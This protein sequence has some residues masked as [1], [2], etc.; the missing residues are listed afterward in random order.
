MKV[1][2][3]VVSPGG[4][5]FDINCGVRLLRTDLNSVRLEPRLSSLVDN[6]YRDIP[7]GLGTQGRIRL[8]A[9][10]VDAVLEKGARWAVEQGYGYLEDLSMTEESGEMLGADAGLVS[11]R[12]KERGAGQLGTLGSGNHFVEIA[13]VDEIYDTETART[14]GLNNLEQVVLWIHT[15]SRG[16]GHQVADD[17]IKTMLKAMARYSIQVPDRQLACSPVMSCESQQYL[18]AMRSAANYAWTNRQL[19]THWARQAFVKTLGL[20][21]KDIG[22]QMVYDIAHNIAKIETHQLNGRQV[23][24]CVHRKGATRAFPP[25]HPD[26]PARYRQVGQPVLIPGDM[27]RYSFVMA[28]TDKAMQDTFGSTCH[29]AGRLKSRTAAKKSI[30]GREFVHSLEQRGIRVRAGSISSVAE[31]ASGAYKDI[32]RIIEVAHGAGISRKVV[33]T[34]PLGVIKG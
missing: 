1:D 31:E 21:E 2:E 24:L 9:R 6:L 15:G 27:G 23:E 32:S 18:A 16:L 3:G 13:A 4:V 11:R 7:S 28:G 17:Y 20:D 14:M 30:S 8:N 5:G 22:L 10:E 26:I 33:R 12:A 34:R 25:G 19:I 29:G